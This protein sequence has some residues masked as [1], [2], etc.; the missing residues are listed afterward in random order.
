[1]DV[2]SGG[3]QHYILMLMPRLLREIEELGLPHIIRTSGFSER[4]VTTLYFE[5]VSIKR[6]LP[7]NPD[8][9]APEI[10]EHLL[11]CV[12]V[13]SAM[14]SAAS[15]D[16]L[17]QA[18]EQAVQKFLPH[19]RRAIEAEYRDQCRE[20]TV[21][22]RLAGMLR[23]EASPEHSRDLCME[24]IRLER[25]QRLESVRTLSTSSL[26]NHSAHIVEAAKAWV[27]RENAD[28][29]E[30]FSV[31]DLVIRLLDL[32]KLVLAIE[33]DNSARAEIPADFSVDKIVLGIGNALYRKE[34]GLQ[35]SM[36]KFPHP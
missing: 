18:R 24:A 20:G 13:M 17:V 15:L 25:E 3:A 32:L 36:V 26:G 5:F 4:E 35:S 31:M 2:P 22:L 10:W 21:D 6:V 8:R 16:D 23:D 1:M 29:P 12:Q 9:I 33:G 14:V 7:S 28:P 11:Y 19:A 34:L 27:V 30:D